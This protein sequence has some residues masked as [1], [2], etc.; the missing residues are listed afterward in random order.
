[1]LYTLSV[2][3]WGVLL[4]YASNRD[5]KL[6]ADFVWDSTSKV[7]ERRLVSGKQVQKF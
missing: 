7:E 1:M 4:H 5:V 6:I 3:L 2:D